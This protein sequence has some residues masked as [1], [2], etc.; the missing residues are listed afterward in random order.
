M[1]DKSQLSLPIGEPGNLSEE[2]IVRFDSLAEQWWDPKGKYKTALA[3]N[4]AR[5]N[6]I[7][8]A[9]RAHFNIPA[10]EDFTKTGLSVL[11]VGC[12]GGLISEPLAALKAKVTGIDAS[13]VSIQVARRHAVKEDLQIDY[14]HCLASDLDPAEQQFDVVINAEVVEHVPDQQQLIRDCCRHVKPGGLLVLATINRNWLSWLIA[15]VGAEYVLRL[16][17]AGTHSWH[18]FVKPDELVAWSAMAGFTPVSLTGMSLNP[19]S[20]K[21]RL[22]TRTPVNYILCLSASG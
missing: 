4:Q 15:I 12:G 14:R 3:F 18:K 19:V 21:W 9:I 2:E 7:I 13:G 20:G 8:P 6:F 22:S 1:L 5:M 16:L 11:D 17:P 10:S